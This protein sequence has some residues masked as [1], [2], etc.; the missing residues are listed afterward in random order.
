MKYHEFKIMRK[1]AK[2][3]DDPEKQAIHSEIKKKVKEVVNS[4]PEFREFLE[5]NKVY[6]KFIK[7]ATKRME[8]YNQY[9]RHFYINR[10][11]PAIRPIDV[12]FIWRNTPQ[13]H[14]FWRKLNN[15]QT[16]K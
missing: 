8:Q 12:A 2:S 16:F 1:C 7:N 13:G 6:G 5:K 4:R 3:R 11:A 15:S 10:I 9:N 14:E